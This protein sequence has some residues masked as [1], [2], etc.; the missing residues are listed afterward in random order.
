MQNFILIFLI[1]FSVCFLIGYP[2][3]KFLTKKQFN[4][5]ILEYVEIHSSKK[6]TPTMGGIMFVVSAIIV[7]LIFCRENN[8]LIILCLLSMFGFALIGFLDDFIKIKFK[9]NLGLTP[10]QK[11]IGQGGIALILSL[12]CYFSKYNIQTFI[13]FSQTTINLSLGIIFIILFVIIGTVNSV[14]LIDGLDGLATKVTL[15]Y[16]LAFG[17]IITITAD[18]LYYLGYSE[19]DIFEMQNMAKGC[20]SLAGSL[21]AF[22]IFNCNKAKVFMGD[23]GSLAL[24]GFVAS[25]GVLSG[26]WLYIPILGVLYVVTALSVILQVLYYKKTK[27][28]IFLMAP[29]HHHFEQKGVNEQKIVS[30]YTILSIIIAL[31]CIYFTM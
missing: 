11:V 5:T 31:I 12:F 1:S 13:P 17:V 28:R 19:L 23:V 22:L 15:V 9:R 3:V 6:N 25:V 26:L 10:V 4:Q 16:L 24:G 30:I 8:F 18:K 27:K 2:Y 29:L 14:N 20:I 7:N 21:L